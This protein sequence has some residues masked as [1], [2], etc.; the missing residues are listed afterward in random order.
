MKLQRPATA[1]P[2]EPS[3]KEQPSPSLTAPRLVVSAPSKPSKSISPS[4]MR[5]SSVPVLRSKPESPPKNILDFDVETI[6]AG[7]ADPDWVPQKITCVAWSWVGED[8]VHSR[9]C[10]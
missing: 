6:A 5:I 8:T 1:K 7:F 4:L 10:G 3:L 9:I 2:L